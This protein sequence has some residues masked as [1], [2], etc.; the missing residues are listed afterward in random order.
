MDELSYID[1]GHYSPQASFEIAKS[2]YLKI[3]NDLN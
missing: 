2:I 1:A 3:F